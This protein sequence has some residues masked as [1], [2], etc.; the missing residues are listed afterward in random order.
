VSLVE[1]PSDEDLIH[2]PSEDQE[3]LSKKRLMDLDRMGECLAQV[4]GSRDLYPEVCRWL[5]EMFETAVLV[6]RVP[7]GAG[8]PPGPPA[9]LACE[10]GAAAEGAEPRAPYRLSQRTIRAAVESGQAVVASNVPT[11]N[12]F[13]TLAKFWGARA[14]V[15]PGC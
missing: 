3:S 5:G 8:A 4:I 11:P 10:G 14:P 9:V 12:G 15:E 13:Q 7:R 6:L 1:A 2:R